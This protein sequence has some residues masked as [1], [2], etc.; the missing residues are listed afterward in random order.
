[1]YR[2]SEVATLID[3]AHSGVVPPI[4]NLEDADEAIGFSFGLY[5][6]E[7]GQLAHPG[8]VNEA[9]AHRVVNDE[10]LRGKNMT[11]QEELA[12]AIEALDPTL[13]GQI[14]SIKTIKKPGRAHRTHEVLKIA[15]PS[16]AERQVGS[17]AVIAFRHHLPRAVAQVK[18]AGFEVAAPSMSGVGDFD[19]NSPQSWIHNS[20]AWMRREC[21]VIVA[22]ALLN[23]I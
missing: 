1:M 16:L 15:S 14:D 2:V 11:L 21:K 6:D 8:P 23:Q 3:Q 7:R 20:R 17:L 18:K 4:G 12:I 5:F 9:I 19:P 10:L 13:A 22:L